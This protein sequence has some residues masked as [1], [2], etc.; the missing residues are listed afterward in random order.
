M[1]R[2]PTCDVPRDILEVTRCAKPLG[3]AGPP[4]QPGGRRP[5]GLARFCGGL[6]WHKWECLDWTRDSS[7]SAVQTRAALS[8]LV[9]TGHLRLTKFRRK[10]LR[11]RNASL[12]WHWPISSARPPPEAGGCCIALHTSVPAGSP[13]GQPGIDGGG[14]CDS[15]GAQV[16]CG[17]G[18]TPRSQ[19]DLGG[20]LVFNCWAEGPPG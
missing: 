10:F 12:W 14:R 3:K 13:V 2:D 17:F 11:S 15:G 4:G 1:A 7:G 20:P 16:P 19:R 18:P 5:G 6:P 8:T 9:A